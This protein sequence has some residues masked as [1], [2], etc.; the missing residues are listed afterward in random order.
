MD[1]TNLVNAGIFFLL[2]SAASSASA[3]DLQIHGKSLF[4]FS[5]KHFVIQ[6]EKAFFQIEKRGL[7]P[8]TL[9]KLE[10][11]TISSETIAVNIPRSK[12]QYIWPN[13]NSVPANSVAAIAE[14]PTAEDG[15][16]VLRGSLQLSFSEGHFLVLDQKS[17][18]QIAKSALSENEIE[19]FTKAGP[20]T[21]IV[22]AVPEA[23]ILGSWS[24]KQSPAR[25]LASLEEPDAFEVR[26][27]ILTMS[28]TILYSADSQ[29]VIV[30]SGPT[31]YR[32]R[33]NG[34]ATKRPDLLDLNGSRVSLTVAVANIAAYW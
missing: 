7:P 33:R 25:K 18:Y 31:V 14:E 5:G 2:L 20:G 16:T 32:L 17:I 15:R 34:I 12:I 10:N 23:A 13:L 11:S 29:F 8:A 22:I 3:E 4:T 19:K 21:S 1:R 24:F 27:S 9:S 28:G 6:S 26:N 30:Q